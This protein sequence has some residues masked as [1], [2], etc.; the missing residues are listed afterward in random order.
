MRDHNIHQIENPWRV[1]HGFDSPNNLNLVNKKIES[2]SQK[3]DSMYSLSPFNKQESLKFKQES[4]CTRK[5]NS[6]FTKDALRSNC[7]NKKTAECTRGQKNNCWTQRNQ[8]VQ[9]TSPFLYSICSCD[10]YTSTTQRSTAWSSYCQCLKNN[11]QIICSNFLRTQDEFTNDVIKNTGT[12]YHYDL[13]P[14]L[15]LRE[16]IGRENVQN[17]LSTHVPAKKSFDLLD[18]YKRKRNNPF[19]RQVIKYILE[20][21]ILI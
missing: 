3:F 17:K 10:S 11:P 16:R 8:Y 6:P 18:I 5:T 13:L 1:F 12:F 4:S 19:N 9:A 21:F 15:H 20:I 2:E 14:N 7:D